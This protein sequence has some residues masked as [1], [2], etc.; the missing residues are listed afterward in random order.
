MHSTLHIPDKKLADGGHLSRLY[1]GW[2]IDVFTGQ[3]CWLA[4]TGSQ[5]TALSTC[6]S[7]V[8]KRFSPS[9]FGEGH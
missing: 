2:T 7:I 5:G 6:S 4:P 8:T 3:K 1:D 9:A